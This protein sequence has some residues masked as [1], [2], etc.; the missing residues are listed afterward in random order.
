[1]DTRRSAVY[2]TT[3]IEKIMAGS[4]PTLTGRRWTALARRAFRAV[5]V[6]Q[7]T[8]FQNNDLFLMEA[9]L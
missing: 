2:N 5:S 1:M 7:D 3:V 4:G 6:C 9:S 8:P